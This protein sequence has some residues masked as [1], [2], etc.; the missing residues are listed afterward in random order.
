[1]ESMKV[2]NGHPAIPH[3][4]EQLKNEI[5]ALSEFQKKA[6]QAATYLG[7]T[8]DEANEIEARR[9]KITALTN[10]LAELKSPK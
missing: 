2:H 9:K 7:M 10:Q 8:P 6:L 4:A 5:D 3:R 1:M